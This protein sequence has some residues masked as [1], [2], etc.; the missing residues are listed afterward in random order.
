MAEE[1]NVYATLIHYAKFTLKCAVSHNRP[2]NCEA[3][4]I[5]RMADN[6]TMEVIFFRLQNSIKFLKKIIVIIVKN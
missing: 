4:V 5:I 1:Y 3:N 6:E 2:W